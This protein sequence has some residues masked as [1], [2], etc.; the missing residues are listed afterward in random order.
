LSIATSQ[1]D[2]ALQWRYAVKAFDPSRSIDPETWACLENSLVQSP[3]SY[4][5]QPW[6]FLLIT[7]PA[8]RAQLRPHS[9]IDFLPGL[10]AGDS[11]YAGH[12]NA[13]AIGWVGASQPAATKAVDL[14]AAPR[15]F[16]LSASPAARMF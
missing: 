7:D 9:W 3:S 10:K 16:R 2:A 4:G 1:I 8:L 12:W 11:F 6:K 13:S 5:L 14:C 15:P